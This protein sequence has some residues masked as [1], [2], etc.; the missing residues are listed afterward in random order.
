M[1][2]I[3]VPGRLSLPDGYQ[4]AEAGS[5][6]RLFDPLGTLLQEVPQGPAAAS[7]LEDR[8]WR[9]AFE[10][11]WGELEEELQALREGTR[12]LRELRRLRQHMRLLDAA[13]G[14]PLEARERP[15][16]R[17]L[18]AGLTVAASAVVFAAGVLTSPMWFARGPEATQP[19]LS[20]APPAAK[21]P[22]S[23]AASS[24][25]PSRKSPQAQVENPPRASVRRPVGRLT[26]PVRTVEAAGLVRELSG[27]KGHVVSVGEFAN[28]TA[29]EIRMHLIRSKGYVVYVWRIGD[30]FHVMTRPYQTQ[31]QAEYLAKAL[32]EIGLP[33]RARFT[34]N[35]TLI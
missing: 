16:S 3:A 28:Q 9:D 32:Q 22:G 6:L 17:F 31:T 2:G 10:R 20:T 8:A 5:H 34:S 27:L 35:S 24:T 29:A 30:S 23:S 13:T 18:V 14:V 11:V 19:V 12:P 33:A 21:S 1:E 26:R 15:H 4:V 7:A 25:A